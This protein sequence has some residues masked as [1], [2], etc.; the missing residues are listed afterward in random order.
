MKLSVCLFSGFDC[1]KTESEIAICGHLNEN[2]E[3]P[4]EMRKRQT[5]RKKNE[6]V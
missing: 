5:S 6:Q 1:V 3:T 4:S 2:K